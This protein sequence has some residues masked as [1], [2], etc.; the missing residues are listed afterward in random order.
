MSEATEGWCS[1]DIN[2]AVFL[3]LRNNKGGG[4]EKW[5]QEQELQCGDIQSAM[6]RQPMNQIDQQKE[7]IIFV[8]Y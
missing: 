5:K 2:L 7:A 1:K 4:I 8:F 6:I 3:I